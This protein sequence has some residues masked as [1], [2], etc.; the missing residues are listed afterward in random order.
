M[1]ATVL[2]VAGFILTILQAYVEGFSKQLDKHVQSTLDRMGFTEMDYALPSPDFDP[3][4]PEDKRDI[5]ASRNATFRVWSI[6]V[7]IWH[8]GN[9][10]F[11][12]GV[13]W[14]FL[15]LVVWLFTGFFIA[16]FSHILCM[17][18]FTLSSQLLLKEAIGQ[19]DIA[20]GIGVTMAFVGVVLHSI[21]LYESGSWGA[22]AMMWACVTLFVVYLWRKFTS[23]AN[24]EG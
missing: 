24:D 2:I 5:V 12:D 6:V 3:D 10:E 20:T 4:I 19:G 21:D 18:I 17:F 16:I 23:R 13:I 8:Y 1:F 9:I 15:E 14:F 22:L 11:G 7:L